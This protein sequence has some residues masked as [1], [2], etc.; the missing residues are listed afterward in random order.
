MKK[1]L[2]KS[3]KKV[4]TLG[5]VFCMVFGLAACAKKDPNTNNTDTTK[6]T[7]TPSSDEQ[8]GTPV[9]E[10]KSY[11]YNL[12]VGSSPTNWNPHTWE[13]S[14][15][16]T[17]RDYAGM[18][19]VDVSI[20]ADGV[21]FEWVYEMATGITDIT[22]T[23]A[24]K[25]KW[26]IEAT[27]Q[28]VYQIDL[29]PDAKWEDGTPINA[30]TYIYSMKQLLD[31]GMKN[32]RANTYYNGTT[33]IKNAAKYF[34]NDKVGQPIYSTLKDMGF[35]TVAE[36]QAAGHTDI[37][38]DLENAWSVTDDK[39]NGI[40]SITDD[41]MYRDK[42][43]EEGK[44]EA[45]VSGKYIY[46]NYFTAGKQYES[47]QAD[48]IMVVS[49]AYEETPWDEVGLVKTGD[50]QIVYITEQPVSMFYFLSG[51]TSNWIVYEE[52]YE[53]SKEQKEG[54]TA[55]KY[56]T[57]VD[58][59]KSFGPYKL[60]SFETDKQFVFEKNENWYGYTDGKHEGQ[61]Q[62]TVVKIDV[63]PDHTTQLQL[64][65]QGL[66][67]EVE[68]SADD[69]TTYRMSDY[70]LKTDQT[71]TFR[72]IFGTD[73]NALKAL[74]EKAGDGANK[75]VLAYDDFRKAISLSMD[76][77]DFVTQAT[78][79]FKPAYFLLNYLYYY[80][81]ENNS[82]SQY[83][84]TEVAK[85]A[86]LDLYGIKYGAG[87][88][89]ATVDD[90][91][92]A[93]TGYD[94]DEARALFQSVYEKAIADG[95]YT[96]GQ[97]I[98]FTAMISANASLSAEDTKQQDLLNAYVTEA[99]K[100]TGFEG[101][102]TFTFTSGSS[103]RYDD[104]ANGKIEMIRGAWGGAAFYPFSTIRVYTEPDYM[105]GLSKIHESNGWDPTKE[106]VTIKYDFDGDGTPEEKTETF[107]YWAKSLNGDGAYAKASADT[108]LNILAG[109]ETGILSAYQAIPWGTQTLCSLFSQQI[110]Y[111]TTNYNIMYGYGGV[112]LMTYNYDD[113][114]WSDY[115]ASQGGTLN[116]E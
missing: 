50:Y 95:N 65:N 71:Y 109:L 40:F 22:A 96:D 44:P 37:Y 1:N 4:L 57:S 99:T 19:L 93:V 48:Y 30:D 35:A 10:A 88:E 106:T 79:G 53:A 14:G 32:Y 46:D 80:D 31:P 67:D 86:V 114:A 54:L 39:G 70:L 3:M 64:F 91:Y 74:E 94:V 15:D 9:E 68:L 76:R 87:T 69:M 110:E 26:G 73:L 89:Y 97:L 7:P 6:T 111:A 36:A 49:G 18:G 102:I 42:S 20:A 8:G 51:M 101:K 83:R 115:V 84:N 78:A 61:Y 98:N 27:E 66:L 11:T 2:T 62:T 116:Y 52:I 47:Y 58:T 34:N 85:K 25:A 5:L 100:G 29:N 43:V 82:E 56:G 92:N 75:R 81:I 17:I 13:S 21:N 107:Q 77:A 38:I 113:A 103:T 23:Y 112:R 28:V 45:S 105:G 90:A 41:T 104:V 108:Q 24:D 63:I 33:A 16:D 12:A 72:F 60:V 59:F 55:T